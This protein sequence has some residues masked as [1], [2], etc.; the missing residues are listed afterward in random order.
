[1]HIF[2][3]KMLPIIPFLA[4]L[5][6]SLYLKC[7]YS[8]PDIQ[9]ISP[10]QVLSSIAVIAILP[11]E[12]TCKVTNTP[13]GA[14]A[15]LESFGLPWQFLPWVSLFTTLCGPLQARHA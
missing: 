6:L 15:S 12:P 13:S 10:F 14:P 3:N 7:F 4:L 2:T 8:S 9:P 5:L 1:M 11:F